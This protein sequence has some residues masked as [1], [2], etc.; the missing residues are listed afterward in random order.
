[1]PKNKSCLATLIENE[2]VQ[3]I[4]YTYVDRSE[5]AQFVN[6]SKGNFDFQTIDLNEA[7]NTTIR[8]RIGLPA[9]PD[10]PAEI[11]SGVNGRVWQAEKLR[12]ATGHELITSDYEIFI[13]TVQARHSKA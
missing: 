6:G 5:G 11:L 4:V 7:F 1:M 10:I 13:R 2:K 3:I 9:Q 12:W 8:D